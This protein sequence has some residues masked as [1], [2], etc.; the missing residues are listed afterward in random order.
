MKYTNDMYL[1]AVFS[2]SMTVCFLS[3]PKNTTIDPAWASN[4]ELAVAT[5]GVSIRVFCISVC[6][7]VRVFVCVC[8]CRCAC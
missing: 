1:I 4:R 6:M 2:V 7:C 8:V 5:L 3:S